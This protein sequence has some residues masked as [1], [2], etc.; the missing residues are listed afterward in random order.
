[1][2]ERSIISA[3]S[4]E[5]NTLAKRLLAK[6]IRGIAKEIVARGFATFPVLVGWNN[7]QERQARQ[8]M[9]IFALKKDSKSI[10]HDLQQLQEKMAYLENNLSRTNRNM[11]SASERRVSKKPLEAVFVDTSK[12]KHE[13]AATDVNAMRNESAALALSLNDNGPIENEESSLQ[14]IIG[15][16]IEKAVAD[17]ESEIDKMIGEKI[18]KLFADKT[19]KINKKIREATSEFVARE[20][21]KCPI[22]TEWNEVQRRLARIDR[23]LWEQSQR[24]NHQTCRE[25]S[26]AWK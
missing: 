24:M 18:E 3:V 26:F 4:D 19:S 25:N 12:S 14:I 8:K 17:K 1:M 15:T 20:M 9:E 23:I 22:F 2:T 11:P 21:A 13:T 6:M 16:A 5:K 10:K 7:F